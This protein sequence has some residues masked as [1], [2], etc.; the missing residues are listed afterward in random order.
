MA[1]SKLNGKTVVVIGGT[2]GIG[3][4]VAKGAHAEGAAVI[5]ASSSDAKV[6]E[7]VTEMGGQIRGHVLDVTD[8]ASVAA[9]F[10]KIGPF[11]HLVFAAGDSG[12][13]P[14]A[15]IGELNLDALKGLFTVRFWSA[16]A[17]I[18]Y[19]ARQIAADG[20]ITLTDGMFAHRPMKGA[21]VATAMLGAV[22]YLVK[23]LAF[24]MAPIRV[25]TVCPG[26]TMTDR[27]KVFPE[28]ML[29]ARA[30]SLPMKRIGQP[31][32]VAEAYLYLMRGGYTTGQ[33]LRV[34]G[35][36]SLI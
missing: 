9:F 7:A 33:V 36:S 24:D 30:A 25:N 10:E 5:V 2:A 8:E 35:G 31:D 21:A 32:D 28:E 19:G 14:P 27:T 23:G 11:D 18:K 34:D 13:V 17:A 22:E 12:Y 29:K 1:T 3:F 15:P 26:L 4:A 20:S 16:L 6:S